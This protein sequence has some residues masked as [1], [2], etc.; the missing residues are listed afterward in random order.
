ME[1]DRLKGIASYV[2]A[3][4]ARQVAAELPLAD[5]PRLDRFNGT[6]LFADVSGFTA[7]TEALARRGDVG[8][9][10]LTRCLNAYFGRL[11]DLIVGAGGD[12]LKFAG[13]ALIAVWY[14]DAESVAT[15]I[16]R[17]AQCS[18][19]VQAQLNGFQAAADVKLSLRIGMSAGEL[20]LLHVGGVNGRRE[21]VATGAPLAAMGGHREA[22]PGA[23]RCPP[24]P[25]RS[26]LTTS[27]ASRAQRRR[28]GLRR[29]IADRARLNAA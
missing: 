1:A 21:L 2:P 3:R 28:A 16:R 12:I 15:T 9:E 5:G 13:D 24:T 26:S 7:L 14:A 11:I 22:K 27:S 17:A 8:A 6:L 18:L 29:A 20:A 23:S 25:G 19:A 4:V 10:E